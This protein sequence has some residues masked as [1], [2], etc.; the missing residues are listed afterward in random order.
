MNALT[1]TLIIIA[2]LIIG[3]IIA[4]ILIAFTSPYM[5][6]HIDNPCNIIIAWPILIILL[7]ILLL[8][9]ILN[10]TA[11]FVGKHIRI[12]IHKTKG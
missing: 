1:I 9:A 11:E 3:V 5:T 6:N 12:I 7:M 2:Y 8:T 4:S 10:Y